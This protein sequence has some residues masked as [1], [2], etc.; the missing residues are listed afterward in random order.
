MITTASNCPNYPSYSLFQQDI[1][2]ILGMLCLVLPYESAGVVINDQVQLHSSC[3][4]HA[5]SRPGMKIMQG[6]RT[7]S[8]AAVSAK[9]QLKR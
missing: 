8:V 4:P 6:P 1:T 2:R 7:K 3:Q 5:Y 9:Q